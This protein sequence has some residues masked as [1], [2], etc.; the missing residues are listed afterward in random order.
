[1]TNQAETDGSGDD[2]SRAS[3]E[4]KAETSGSEPTKAPKR[5]SKA[6][7]GGAR[8]GRRAA[9]TPRHQRPFPSVSFE[10]AI[11]LGEAVA[12]FSGGS[13]R[14]RRIT[15]FEQLG[16]APDSGPSRQLVTNSGKYGVTTGGYQA[17]FIELTPDGA[18]A[19]NSDLAPRERA[20]AR[21]AL[22]IEGIA[23]FKAL[24]DAYASYKLPAQ[25]VMRDQLVES[26][27]LDNELAQEA[28]E[29]FIVNAKSVGILRP[30]SGTERILTIE[31]AL[32][33]LPATT[34]SPGVADNGA[35][36]AAAGST[37]TLTAP[38]SSGDVEWGSLCFYVSPIGSNESE[39]R[40][41]SDVALGQ[42]V[43]PAIE[44]L[45]M[46]LTV[47]RAD[48]IDKPGL[49]TAQ[50]I[51]HIVKA[52]LVIVDLSFHNPNVFYELALRHATRRPAVLIT[53]A[54]DRIPFDIADVRTI[55]FDMT[56]IHSFVTQ[57]ET[58][59]AELTNQARQALADPAS[60]VTPLTGVPNEAF[61]TS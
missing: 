30:V 20:R 28:V 31:H 17:E 3:P 41:H 23:A 26:E 33:E 37:F 60:A 19:T 61:L 11:V 48:Q 1:M 14:I 24:Y 29:L 42:I 34:P 50:V 56:D 44:A 52:R 2:S 57:M 43:E 32:D 25:Q 53:R 5:R 15:L 36:G 7:A 9:R 18:R 45:G 35:A 13:A 38:A 8:A 40:K 49:I 54:A 59:R 27:S 6:N 10:E 55:R 58:W 21:F 22:G 51:E 12:K 47:V 46:G 4:P 39:E 16:K